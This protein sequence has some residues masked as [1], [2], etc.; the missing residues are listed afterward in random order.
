MALFTPKNIFR[1]SSTLS[2]SVK[3]NGIILLKCNST[4]YDNSCRIQ[5]HCA[6]KIRHMVRHSCGFAAIG[7]YNEIM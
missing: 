2:R 6:S 5:I 3:F 1:L 4:Y 7:C